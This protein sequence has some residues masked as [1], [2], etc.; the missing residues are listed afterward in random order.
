MNISLEEAWKSIS[1]QL[2]KDGIYYKSLIKEIPDDVWSLAK[3]NTA[4]K[5]EELINWF[6]S[7]IP[8]FDNKRLIDIAISDGEEELRRYILTLPC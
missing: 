8:A 3:R 4:F 6:N 5:D 1:D 7:E 2:R